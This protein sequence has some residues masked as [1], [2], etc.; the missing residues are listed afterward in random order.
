MGR[1][2]LCFC[3]SGFKKKKCHDDIHES[4]KAAR[5]LRTYNYVDNK[6]KRHYENTNHQAPC[7]LGCISCCSD[8]VS[9]TDIEFELILYEVNNWSCEEKE[10]L[11]H[12]S[13]TNTKVFRETF[14]S[15][16]KYF[17][18]DSTGSSDR[19]IQLNNIPEKFKMPCVFLDQENRKCKIYKVRPLICR[20]FGVSYSFENSNTVV[21]DII[22]RENDARNWQADLI[23][24][25]EERYRFDLL[26]IDKNNIIQVKMYPIFYLLDYRHRISKDFQIIMF[27]DYF[28]Q[29]ESILNNKFR[30]LYSH[31]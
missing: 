28:R 10:K 14:P 20:L 7:K 29:P 16:F 25:N 18:E 6:I 23:E 8:Y 5:L 1:N 9:I 31:F 26:M 19:F 2:D 17:E 3:G 13:I 30:D 24:I 27:E 4:S 21:C 22:G 11:L 12:E 15:I